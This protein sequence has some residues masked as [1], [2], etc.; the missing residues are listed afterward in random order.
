MKRREFLR[1]ATTLVG[2]GSA[3][4]AVGRAATDGVFQHGVASGDPLPDGVILWT[5]ITPSTE[6]ERAIDVRWQVATD[7]NMKQVVVRGET[8]T[9]RLRDYTVKIDVR[10]LNPATRY[11]YRFQA[12]RKRSP[13]G[14]TL[15][16]AAGGTP[17]VNFAV[18][19]CANYPFG[20]FNVYRRI[21]ERND[22]DAVLHLG[23]Y[24]YEY[25]PGV[26][27]GD[28]GLRSHMPD[29]EIISLA[30]YRMRHAQYKTDPD[31]QAAHQAHP[32][33]CVWDDHESTNNSWLHGA[34]NHNDGEGDWAVRKAAAVQAYHEWMPIREQPMSV[35]LPHIYRAFRF[36]DT[37]DLLMLDT[38][39]HGRSEQL[40]ADDPKLT[41]PSRSLL[42]ADQMGWLKRQ[43][44]ASRDRHARWRVLGQQCMFGQLLGDQRQV[45]NSDQWDGYPVARQQIIDHLRD[46]EITNNVIL[47]GDIHSSWALDITDDPFGDTYN[48]G[49]GT[50][51]TELVTPSVTSPPPFG[52]EQQAAAREQEVLDQLPHV[53]WVNFRRRGYLVARFSA[54]YSHAEWWLVDTVDS[55][56]HS[57][58]KAVTM[59]NEAGSNRLTKA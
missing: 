16:T 7:P 4:P 53:Q 43:L 11:Y 51:A 10:G 25:P 26:Y 21:A 31:L 3:L 39:L 27:S 17:D 20:H 45:L 35:L 12:L 50:V 14:R 42:G 34:Q 28:S 29:R 54:L 30:D 19:S 58:S 44:N 9:H 57:E 56:Q 59:V 23:D 36:G 37:V 49:M 40:A 18:A 5:R 47:T 2:A 13:I 48:N 24:L 22:L 32:W 1:R 15:T 8:Q 6:T 33:I 38:R 41:D 55:L 52:D 46:G